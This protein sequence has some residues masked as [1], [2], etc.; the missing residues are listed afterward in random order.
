[1]KGEFP[2]GAFLQPYEVEDDHYYRQLQLGT[3]TNQCSHCGALHWLQ[4]RLSGSS[5]RNPVFSR[6]CNQ[7]KVSLPLLQQVPEALQLLLGSRKDILGHQFEF[8]AA[9]HDRWK[10]FH[11]YIH[12]YNAAFSFVSLGYKKDDCVQGNGPPV[13]KIHGTLAHYHGSL[14]PDVSSSLTFRLFS[15]SPCSVKVT[16]RPIIT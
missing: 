7:G 13:F 4:E 1:M 12:A 3:M 6:C 16:H 2:V 8:S 10:N 9:Q 15:K 14:L 11:Q 5:Q